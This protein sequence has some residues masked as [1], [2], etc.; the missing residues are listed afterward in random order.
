MVINLLVIIWFAVNFTIPC[1]A[2]HLW[3]E[4]CQT[5]GTFEAGRVPSTVQGLKKVPIVDK[6]TTTSTHTWLVVD[7]G[8]WMVAW[9]PLALIIIILFIMSLQRLGTVDLWN[10]VRIVATII[11]ITT[12]LDTCH[13]LTHPRT[14]LLSSSLVRVCCYCITDGSHFFGLICY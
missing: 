10:E 6:K 4:T 11:V 13:P 2:W 8:R 9:W 14:I 12:C 3:V 1:K 7:D 5:L